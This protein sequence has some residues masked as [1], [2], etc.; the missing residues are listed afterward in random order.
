MINP[1][2]RQ[3]LIKKIQDLRGSKVLVYVTGDRPPAGANIGE[4]AVRPMLEHLRRIG[5]VDQLDVFIYSRGGAVDVPWR[6]NCAFR[7]TADRWNALVPFRANS[8][9]TLLCLAADEI[10]LGKHGELGPIDPIVSRGI[11]G[12]TGPVSDLRN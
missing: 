1:R 3:E 5:Q 8:A 7:S 12:Q 10:V 4:D 11:P 6:M 9:A 2:T